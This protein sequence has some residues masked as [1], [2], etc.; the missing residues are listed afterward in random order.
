MD[1]SAY[2][3]IF[4]ENN[5]IFST[6]CEKWTATEQIIAVQGR[7]KKEYLYII[8]MLYFLFVLERRQRCASV[9]HQ[10]SVRGR[11]QCI[12]LTP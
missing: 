7:K 11:A 4:R 3:Q 1:A 8:H 10:E 2:I 9:S 5:I 6:G 12:T